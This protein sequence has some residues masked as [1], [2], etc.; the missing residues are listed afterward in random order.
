MN[1][2]NFSLGYEVITMIIVLVI[3]REKSLGTNSKLENWMLVIWL[4]KQLT[5]PGLGGLIL[6]PPCNDH[7]LYS[8]GCAYELLRPDFQLIPLVISKIVKF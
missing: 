1:Q 7:L 6:A 2:A 4:L 3:T 5:L 8:E